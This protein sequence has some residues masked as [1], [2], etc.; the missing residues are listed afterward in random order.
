MREVDIKV[1][2]EEFFVYLIFVCF[3][4]NKELEVGVGF[5]V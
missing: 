1:I 5:V 3:V 4:S 2:E